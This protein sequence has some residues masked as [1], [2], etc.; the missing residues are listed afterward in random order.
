MRVLPPTAGA[1][2]LRDCHMGPG[3]LRHFVINSAAELNINEGSTSGRFDSAPTTAAGSLYLLSGKANTRRRRLTLVGR[4]H[5]RR[6]SCRSMSSYLKLLLPHW[7]APISP[8][9]APK[10]SL[11]FASLSRSIVCR[12]MGY[13]MMHNATQTAGGACKERESGE[14]RRSEA[15]VNGLLLY[16]AEPLFSATQA[17]RSSRT[18]RKHCLQWHFPGAH[19]RSLYTGGVN[20]AADG[21]PPLWPPTLSR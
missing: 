2:T 17:C 4:E 12:E 8:R 20:A 21:L 13:L 6:L 1:P 18:A 14:E 7:S 5:R 19:A 10:D 9:A 15:D 3:L 16:F 11:L